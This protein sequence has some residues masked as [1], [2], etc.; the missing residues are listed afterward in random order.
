MHVVIENQAVKSLVE[1]I[2][3]LPKANLFVWEKKTTLRR[4]AISSLNLGRQIA[5]YANFILH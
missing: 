3:D 1:S 4:Y 5:N 2:F